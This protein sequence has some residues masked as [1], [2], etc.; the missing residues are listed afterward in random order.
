MRVPTQYELTHLQLQAMLR[1]HDIPKSEIEY[2]G[3][4]CYTTKYTAHPEYHGMSMP[5]Y[6]IGG[7][8]KVPVCD[9]Q[10]VDRVDDDDTVPENDGWG[11]QS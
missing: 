5:F 3:D 2:I 7:E 9:I 8:H 11:P 4:R 10:S 6:I 1:D